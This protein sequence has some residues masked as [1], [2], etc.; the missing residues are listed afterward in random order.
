CAD[1]FLMGPALPREHSQDAR[2]GFT[3]EELALIPQDTYFI[4]PANLWPHKNH[5]RI[6]QAFEHFLRS[7][8]RHMELVLTGHQDGW[9]KLRDAFPGLPVR[10]LGYVQPHLLRLLIERAA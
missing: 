9:P 2:D 3:R 5:Y 1:V 6:L 7:T 10:H 4:Y 8:G